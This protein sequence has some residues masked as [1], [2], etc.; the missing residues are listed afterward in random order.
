M[1]E[2][3]LS[4]NQDSKSITT[5]LTQEKASIK[6]AIQE[7]EDELIKLARLTYIARPKPAGKAHHAKA[8]NINYAIFSTDTSGEYIMTLD[9]D[10][11][12]KPHFL[13]RVL[14][15]FHTY[16]IFTGK[17][18]PNRIA[19]VQ[20]PQDFYNV[21]KGDPFGHQAQL[22]YGPILEGK[23][24]MNAAF[25]TGTNAILRREALVNVG[26]QNFAK[27]YAKDNDRINEFEL[28]GGLSSNSITEDMNTAMRLHAAG[29]Q[30]VY[31]N[32]LMACGLAPDDLSSTLKQRLRW[33]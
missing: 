7:K 29:W 8:G 11:I 6:A 33:A 20:T 13:K 23:D 4:S 22:F 3:I 18:E 26:L 28:V 2:L 27:E 1:Q 14:P 30:S 12:V 17:Y 16:N 24:G 21:P 25:Y 31:H 5:R 19:F 9:A 15:Y 32:E 10:H